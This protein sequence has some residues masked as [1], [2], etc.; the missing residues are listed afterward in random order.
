MRLLLLTLKP[1]TFLVKQGLTNLEQ[2]SVPNEW[3]GRY[4]HITLSWISHHGFVI[5]RFE[6]QIITIKLGQRTGK[7]GWQMNEITQ[8]SCLCF[9]ITNSLVAF[10]SLMFLVKNMIHIFFY[11][12]EDWRKRK[13]HIGCHSLSCLVSNVLS[14]FPS[15]KSQTNK[16]TRNP[17]RN[18]EHVWVQRMV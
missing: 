12:A 15:C 11:C 10:S 9:S 8:E 3:V 1:A 17:P 7:K 14:I 6:K 4:S 16:Q 18:I 5:S 13:T 2:T